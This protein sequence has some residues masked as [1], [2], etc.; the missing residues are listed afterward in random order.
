[1]SKKEANI[2]TAKNWETQFYFRLQCITMLLVKNLLLSD[3][4]ILL[5]G[6]ND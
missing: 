2:K 1:M 5:I 4:R 6:R 3:A